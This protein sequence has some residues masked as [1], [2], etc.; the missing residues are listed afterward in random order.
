LGIFLRF[1]QKS[2]TLF[3]DLSTGY[4]E[5]ARTRENIGKI[6]ANK[7]KIPFLAQTLSDR[8]RKIGI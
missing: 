3:A 2:T 4:K 6:A 7:P 1:A 8:G 5:P